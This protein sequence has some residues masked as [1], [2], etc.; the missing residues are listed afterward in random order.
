M[1]ENHVDHQFSLAVDGDLSRGEELEFTAHLAT[2]ERCARTF[3]EFE[4]SVLAMQGATVP[5]LSGAALEATVGAAFPELQATPGGPVPFGRSRGGEGHPPGRSGTPWPL[6]LSHAAAVL[7]GCTLMFGGRA[8][9]SRGGAQPAPERIEVPVEVIREVEVPVEVIVE[10]P[11]EVI[12]EVIREVPV[13]V[14]V[15]RLVPHPLQRRLDAGYGVA[16]NVTDI[17][18]LSARGL[19]GALEAAS[20]QQA[21]RIAELG[22]EEARRPDVSSEQRPSRSD[23]IDG[24]RRSAPRRPAAALVVLRDGE[25]LSLKTRGTR[26]QV[27]P[28]LID[29]LD[30]SDPALAAAAHGQ[31]MGIRARMVASGLDSDSFPQTEE[32]VS[33]SLDAPIDRAGGLRGLLRQSRDEG[34]EPDGGSRSEYTS[35]YWRTWWRTASEF[36]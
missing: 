1:I 27:V 7:I 28:A 26:A 4:R 25:R 2:C 34:V 15:E 3:A 21:M 33:A 29:A 13:E 19:G 11:K 5:P 30:D 14:E 32:R 6:F 12:R 23:A 20:A 17:A 18:L 22:D 31:L 8:M 35:E 24:P 9:F 16:A 10:V 36:E